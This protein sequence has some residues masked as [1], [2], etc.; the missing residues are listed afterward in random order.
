[1]SVSPERDQ[2]NSVPSSSTEPKGTS[3]LSLDSN[4]I[5]NYINKCVAEKMVELVTLISKIHAEV[6][7][8]LKKE[9]NKESQEE[10]IVDQQQ[11]Q[12][13]GSKKHAS[14]YKKNLQDVNVAD[15]DEGRDEDLEKKHVSD[16]EALQ[17]EIMAYEEEGS[18]DE[19]K[20]KCI[21]NMED[22]SVRDHEATKA[23][24][25]RERKKSRILKLPYI[26]K[27]GSISKNE[28]NSD[29]EE[30]KKYAFDEILS[31]GKQVHSCGFDAE[32]Q[33]GRYAS[34]LWH[35]RVTKAKEGYTNDNGDPPQPT[36]RA[37][38]HKL[39]AGTNNIKKCN[40][41]LL[42]KATPKIWDQ[43]RLAVTIE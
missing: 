22:L 43:K 26:T 4:E 41:R 42:E 40:Q 30:K 31:E 34:L 2:L 17:D 3:K 32:S 10:K 5:K 1:M 9:E 35:Y 6:V 12:E 11:S 16:L 19:L 15:K 7:K 20:K 23:P 28:G 8:A 33:R 39:I 21:T 25:K 36:P 27:Y 29:N 14:P 13:E 18:D 37:L 24:V 38:I